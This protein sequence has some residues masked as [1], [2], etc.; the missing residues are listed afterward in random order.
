MGTQFTFLDIELE[1]YVLFTVIPIYLILVG[2]LQSKNLK[3]LS[4]IKRINTSSSEK[5]DLL[6]QLKKLKFRTSFIMLAGIFIHIAIYLVFTEEI[7]HEYFL[8]IFIVYTFFVFFALAN[9]HLKGAS[10]LKDIGSFNGLPGN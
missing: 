5:T 6:K 3:I 10:V 1:S 2:V 4:D 8:S 9:F 7:R